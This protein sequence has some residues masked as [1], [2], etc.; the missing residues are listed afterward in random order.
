[1]FSYFVKIN[2]KLSKLLAKRFPRFFLDIRSHRN[3]L[4]SIIKSSF[5][6][7]PNLRILELGGIDRPL[8]KKSY[9]Y[10][11]SG[12]DIEYKDNCKE[13]YDEFHTQSIEEDLKGNYSIII[14]ATLL[15]HVRNNKKT[16]KNIYN[17]L[18]DGG[19]TFH[20]LPSK[21]HFYSLILRLVG[22]KLQ[23]IIIKHLRPQASLDITGY[24]AFFNLCSINEMGKILIETGFKKIKIIPYYKAGDYFAFFTPLYLL[25]SFFENLFEKFNLKYFASGIIISAE[26]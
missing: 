5:N 23:R 2:L 10:K 20:Y 9:K 7:Y 8:L 11:Y 19:T 25:I 26:K 3:D 15:E 17:A 1:M 12:L 22:P 18:D 4:I 16:F 24:P 21:N 13:L 14:S 6:K